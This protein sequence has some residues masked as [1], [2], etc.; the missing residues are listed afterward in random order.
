MH[1]QLRYSADPAK[2][3]TPKFPLYLASADCDLTGKGYEGRSGADPIAQYVVGD[4]AGVKRT[5][6]FGDDDEVIGASLSGGV[7]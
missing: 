1:F 7:S 4:V 6:G 5:A 2:G 3:S